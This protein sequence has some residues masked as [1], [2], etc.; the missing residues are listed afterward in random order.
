MAKIA[1]FV[2]NHFGVNCYVVWDES[3][4]ALI[5]DPGCVNEKENSS[6]VKD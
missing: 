4:E 6:R 2:F 3:G 1:R 5:V